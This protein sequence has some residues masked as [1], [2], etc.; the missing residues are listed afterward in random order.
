MRRLAIVSDIHYAGPREQAHGSKFEIALAQPSFA[1][2]LLGFF[3]HYIWLRNPLAHNGLLDRFIG[4][5]ASADLVIANGDYTCNV[6]GVGVADDEACESVQLCLGKLRAAF[7]DRFHA[8]MGDHELG[9]VSLLGDH[10]GLRLPSWHRALNDCGLRPFWRLEIGNHVLIGIASTLVAL[11]AFRRDALEAEWPEWERLREAHLVDIRAAFAE[12][13]PE[14]RLV[15]FCHDPTALPFLWREPVVQAHRAQIA[16]TIIGHLHTRLLLWK[17]RLLGGLPPSRRFGVSLHRIT[18]ALHEAKHWRPFNV[19]L[20][21]SLAGI[22]LL[23]DGG[24]LTLDL[25]ETGA[26]PP[27]IEFHP[28]PRGG[29]GT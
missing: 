16:V 2:S 9:K 10:G 23:K 13:R 15:L 3:R 19:R 25:D 29:T 5:A 18:T 27:R 17:S 8:T 4:A 6:S 11:P 14:Q 26:V 24:F 21:P 28:L 12:L 22:E 7:G 1:R 20:C